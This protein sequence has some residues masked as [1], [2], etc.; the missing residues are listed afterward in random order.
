MLATLALLAGLI[1]NPITDKNAFPIGVWLQSPGQAERYKSA[2]FNLYVGLWQGPTEQQLADLTKAG[3]PVICDQNGVGLKHKAD[4]IIAAWMHGDEP[5]NAQ[6]IVGSDGKQTWGPCVPPPKI[7]EDYETIKKNDPSRPVLLNLGQGVAND[8]WIGRGSGAKLSD[9]ETY[10]K[11]CDIVSFDVY[12]VAGLGEP[13]EIGLIGKGLDRLSA[14]T[15][16]KKRLWTV[17]ECTAIDGKMKPTP[18]QVRAEA[19]SAIIHGATGLIYFVHQ[20]APAFNEHALL[21]DP[22]MLRSVTDLN[23]QVQSLAPVLLSKPLAGYGSSNPQVQVAARKWKGAIY[24][25]LVSLSDRSQEAVV[26]PEKMRQT[27]TPYEAKVI[28]LSAES[29]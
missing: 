19:W 7:V 24:V 28:K 15:G 25:F 20:F 14:W 22:E 27:F 29:R 5:D 17:L 12:P 4:P 6:A 1:T 16:G 26:G 21:D 2:G 11:G 3:M 10:V 9:Y 18:L 13:K 8:T 23:K